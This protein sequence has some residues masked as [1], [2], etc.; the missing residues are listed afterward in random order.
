MRCS[1]RRPRL[2]RRGQQTG[3]GGIHRV[4]PYVEPLSLDEAFLDVR[5]PC[6]I[7]PM[8]P[9]SPET[10]SSDPRPG[11]LTCSIGVATVK[12]LA[13]LATEEAKPRATSAG[14]S[15]G[16]GCMSSSRSRACLPASQPARE[17]WGVG[18]KT[19][20]KLARIGIETIGDL[21]A[22]PLDRLTA[23]LGSATGAHLHQLATLEIRGRSSSIPVPSRSGTKRPSPTSPTV[24]CSAES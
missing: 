4:T 5:G 3:H 21:A 7:A 15:S 10:S 1:A 6:A 11:R 22:Q 13:K 2:L 24:P 17:L 12:F 19:G 9:R 16:P 18:P 23:A 8:P 20:E 14:R